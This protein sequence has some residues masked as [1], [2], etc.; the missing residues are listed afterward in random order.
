VSEAIL[1]KMHDRLAKH[2]GARAAGAG[3]L[4]GLIEALLEL[5]KNCFQTPEAV[6]DHLARGSLLARLAVN[7]SVRQKLTDTYGF[8]AWLRYD[9]PALA[10]A[11]MAAGKEATAEDV[12]ALM[13]VNIG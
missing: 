6:A 9:G 10:A 13:A 1:N 7:K 4:D 3:F 2:V 5:L 11:V 12:A 8:G